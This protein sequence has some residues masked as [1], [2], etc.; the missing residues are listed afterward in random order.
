MGDLGVISNFP[1]SRVV[2]S[3]RLIWNYLSGFAS[4]G[5]CDALVVCGSYDLRV[6][7]HA[8]RLLQQKISKTLVITGNTGNWT[9]HLWDRPEA[10]IFFEHGRSRIPDDVEV[11]LERKATN[12][13]ENIL[14]ARDL[15]PDIDSVVLLTKPN[16]VL[17][18]LL[19]AQEQWP[20]TTVSV[21]SPQYRF[22]YDVS[23]VVGLF[24]LIDEMVGDID[25]IRKYPKLGYQV[26]HEL[27]KAVLDA[28]DFLASKGFDNHLA[29]DLCNEER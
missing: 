19:T 29:P 20:E 24:G 8:V 4:E 5:P 13:G 14:F 11:V 1:D 18:V 3:A 22:P 25:R 10:E 6:M 7:D 2:E 12:F 16:A 23:N 17:R 9:K 28:A 27:P 21:S 26:E 15:L